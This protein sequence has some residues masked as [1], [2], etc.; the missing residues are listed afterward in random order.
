MARLAIF[1]ILAITTFP[2]CAEGIKE[3]TGGIPTAFGGIILTDFPNTSFR[4]D[5]PDGYQLRVRV[6]TASERVHLGFEVNTD[7]YAALRDYAD[8]SENVSD[9]WVRVRRASDNSI[10]VAGTQLMP[11]QP[12]WIANMAQA[13]AG[14]AAVVGAAGYNGLVFTPPAAGDY[15]IEFARDND[16]TWPSNFRRIARLWDITV[17]DSA[18]PGAA[19]IRNGRVYSKA[20]PFNT[21]WVWQGGAHHFRG[22]LY[23]YSSDSVVTR[24]E[25]NQFDPFGFVVSCN[26]YG[27]RNDLD[28]TQ[29]RQSNYQ[30]A[31]LADGVEPGLPDY[32]IFL[33]DPDP[34]EF[35]SGIVGELTG[36]TVQ[37]CSNQD[38]CINV[39]VS[40]VGNISVRIDFPNGT[41][42]DFL[43]PVVAG[44]N[45]ISWDGRDGN[46]DLVPN[47][48]LLDITVGYL[49]GLTHL[50][51][52]D[53]ENSG[54]FTVSLV[55][56]ATTPGGTPLSPPPCSTGTTPS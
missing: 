19:G 4:Y 7:N 41:R 9:V 10:V 48:A 42:R 16:P 15:I 3:A 22:S 56:P 20:W 2:L 32:P 34:I 39:A 33:N 17:H 11:G 43:E 26:A 38:Y 44:V 12:G 24:I 18:V 29:N 5:R 14:P 28:F 8:V 25:F 31:L 53:V 23:P 40:N 55:R 36:V 46:G 27:V 37:P 51:L 47:G 21:Y 1:I 30:T 35:P 54:G 52:L 6:R 50:P 49:T 45:C 13:Y